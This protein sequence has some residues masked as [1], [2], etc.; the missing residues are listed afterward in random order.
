[1]PITSAQM[2]AETPELI[3]TT[4]P[5]AKSSAPPDRASSAP[6]ARIP[7]PHTQ[8]HSGQYTNVPQSTMNS[9]IALNFMRSANAPQISAGVM[10][11]NMP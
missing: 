6:N 4:V 9:A 2:S 5:P 7:P 1:M 8:W 3:C 11:K 10:M